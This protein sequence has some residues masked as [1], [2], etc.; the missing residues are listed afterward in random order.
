MLDT[1]FMAYSQDWDE[2]VQRDPAVPQGTISATEDSTGQIFRSSPVYGHNLDHPLTFRSS[3]AYVTGSH[4]YKLGFTLRKRGAGNDFT[5]LAPMGDMT[6]NLLN[7][8]PRQITLFATPIEYHND[9]NADLGIFA[10]DSWTT[11]RLT[12]NYG[13]RFDY[14]RQC[15]GA[16][17]GRRPV[18][19]GA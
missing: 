12:I 6:F 2:R 7:G 14:L 16:A 18:R 19:S 1:G 11:R 3:L 8:V 15:A 17:P 10:Q 4:N 5:S 9:L 13:V